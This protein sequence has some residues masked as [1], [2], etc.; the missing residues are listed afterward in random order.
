MSRWQNNKSETSAAAPA[1]K[2]EIFPLFSAHCRAARH[3][4][5]AAMNRTH[6][7]TA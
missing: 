1:G 3:P 5:S 4:V 7:F 6:E 2:H